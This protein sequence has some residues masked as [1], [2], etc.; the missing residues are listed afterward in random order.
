M[1]EKFGMDPQKRTTINQL[2][3]K[4]CWMLIMTNLAIFPFMVWWFEL[5]LDHKV[6]CLALGYYMA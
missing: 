1:Y 2:V 3:S 5:Y 4:V 6:N